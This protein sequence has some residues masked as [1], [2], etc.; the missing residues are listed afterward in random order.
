M[1]ESKGKGKIESHC[2]KGDS[3]IL[4]AHQGCGIKFGKELYRGG[5][6]IGNI[7]YH[8]VH[9]AI[10]DTRLFCM[11]HALAHTVLLCRNAHIEIPD[12]E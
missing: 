10:L 9:D 4:C 1:E 12:S 5:E 8:R 2:S 11:K 3:F 7:E 6:A